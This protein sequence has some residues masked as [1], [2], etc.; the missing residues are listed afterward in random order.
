[1]EAM[2]ILCLGAGRMANALIAGLIVNSGLRPQQITVSNQRD[3]ARLA[4]LQQQYGVTTT[5][6]WTAAVDDHDVVLLA[7]PPHAHAEILQRLAPLVRGQLV[8]T[9]AAGTGV[10]YLERLLPDGTA[11]A[12]IMPN[13][14]AQV[15]E[16]ISLYA[17]GTHVTTKHDEMLSVLLD[18]IGKAYACTEQEV[19]RLTAI[20]GSSPAIVYRLA[21]ALEAA[22]AADGFT[23]EV[24]S[25][26]VRQMI[27]GSAKMLLQGADTQALANEVASPGGTTEAGLSYLDDAG[28][29]DIIARAVAAI[30]AREDVLANRS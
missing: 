28:F 4:A 13:T 25:V 6:E 10:Q 12:W 22:C 1:M 19:E 17:R 14:A 8:V 20:T 30:H 11:T 24:A 9:V 21:G 5:A 3:S 23:S 29:E 2:R 26:L 27:F 15:G 18:S 7:I 16:S